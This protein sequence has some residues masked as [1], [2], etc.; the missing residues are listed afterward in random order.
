MDTKYE[1]KF[2]PDPDANSLKR[3][4]LAQQVMEV[5]EYLQKKATQ[6]RSPVEDTNHGEIQ[7]FKLRRMRTTVQ[8]GCSSLPSTKQPTS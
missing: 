7:S 5:R 4:A 8:P 2:D 6:T 3:Q 1:G